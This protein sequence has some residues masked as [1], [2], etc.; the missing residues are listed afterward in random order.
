MANDFFAAVSAIG[1][2]HSIV[3][4]DVCTIDVCT[5]ALTAATTQTTYEAVKHRLLLV[6]SITV[7]IPP[8]RSNVFLFRRIS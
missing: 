1:E 7:S 4:F 3:P 5:M 6:E 2:L 8:N